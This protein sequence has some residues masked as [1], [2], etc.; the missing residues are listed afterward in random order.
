MPVALLTGAERAKA[1]VWA[2][3]AR[4]RLPDLDGAAAAAGEARSA[5]V[6]AP[7]SRRHEY[8]H[9]LARCGF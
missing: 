4:L 3:F 2:S 6:S 7:R 5:A 9:G 1:Q 8:R